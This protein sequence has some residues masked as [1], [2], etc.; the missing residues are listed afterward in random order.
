MPLSTMCTILKQSDW[1]LMSEK[2][3]EG[4]SA[5]K[6][7]HRLELFPIFE[8]LLAEWIEKATYAKVLIS[9]EVIKEQGRNLIIELEQRVN[10]ADIQD[11]EEDYTGFELSNG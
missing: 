9:D 11:F 10:I 8:R 1:L 6:I 2:V 7:K 4:A 3:L 5:V